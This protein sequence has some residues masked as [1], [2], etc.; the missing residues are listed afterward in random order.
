MCSNQPGH[1]RANTVMTHTLQI[2][3]CVTAILMLSLM[4]LGACGDN[5]TALE[6]VQQFCSGMR[7]G[8]SLEAVQA[9]YGL[10]GLEPGGMAAAPHVRLVGAISGDQIPAATG[11]LAEPKGS[12]L[13]QPRPVCAIYHHDQFKGGNGAVLLAEFKP[14]Y[15]A[16]N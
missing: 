14:T 16:R 1:V 11:V 8:E 5:R 12:P 10:F 2:S 4:T 3:H 15:A 7:P 13:H 9:R 6:R